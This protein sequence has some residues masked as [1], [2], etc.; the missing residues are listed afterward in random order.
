MLDLRVHVKGNRKHGTPEGTQ[1]TTWAQAALKAVGSGFRQPRPSYQRRIAIRRG[2]RYRGASLQPGGGFAC[3]FL[4]PMA[5]VT[6]GRWGRTGVRFSVYVKCS[7]AACC[8]N[9]ESFALSIPLYIASQECAN[10]QGKFGEAAAASNSTRGS[11]SHKFPYPVGC[12]TT[13]K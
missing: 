1:P 4:S 7:P 2:R 3:C 10:L 12:S 9:R 13:P 6:V 11:S 8:K 5:P